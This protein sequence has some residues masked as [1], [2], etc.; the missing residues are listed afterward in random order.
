MKASVYVATSL[1]GFIA[2]ENGDIDWLPEGSDGKGGEDYGYQAF[3]DSV[4]AIV[5]GRKT[6]ELALSFDVWPYGA[7]P[8]VV[9][10]SRSLAVPAHIAA[11]VE[12]MSASPRDVLRLLAARGFHHFY[13][14][15]GRTIQGFLAEGLIQRLIITRVPILIGRGIP[16]FGPI[17]HDLALRHV[18]TRAFD[19]G[20]VQ[21]EYRV[22][23]R[24]D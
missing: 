23:G 3:I 20:L 14:D 11:S 2:R 4:D 18:R 5:M 8:V 21:S 10:S 1:D 19:D 13:I 16:L 22:Q 7:K 17:S 12:A 24:Q 15:G 6:Y 9:L